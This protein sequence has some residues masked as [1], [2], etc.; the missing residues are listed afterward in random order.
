[1]LN[2][3]EQSLLAQCMETLDSAVSA[4]LMTDYEYMK[5]ADALKTEHG[6]LECCVGLEALRDD[7]D[8]PTTPAQMRL[9]RLLRREILV[10]LHDKKAQ[11]AA[12]IACHVHA[13]REMALKDACADLRR[14]LRTTDIAAM[15]ACLLPVAFLCA[16]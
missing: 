5:W 2:P 14:R 6:R 12:A 3:A 15:C 1:M 16:Y 10:N 13:Q 4:S 9:L 11:W 7:V 8:E